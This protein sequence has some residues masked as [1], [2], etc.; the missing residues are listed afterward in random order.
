MNRV[1]L[2]AGC[3]VA[4]LAAALTRPGSSLPE[5]ILPPATG[6]AAV[7]G[8]ALPGTGGLRTPSDPTCR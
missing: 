5:T 8:G 4:V 2:A 1:R 7:A 6:M 3:G